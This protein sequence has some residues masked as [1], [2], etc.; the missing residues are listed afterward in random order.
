MV[1]T[2]RPGDLITVESAGLRV[3][4]TGE[5]VVFKR[6]GRLVVHRVANIL[7]TPVSLTDGKFRGR[8]NPTHLV[9]RGDRAG[10][11]DS[12]TSISELVGRVTQ[13]ERG[14][15]HVRLRSNLTPSEKVISRMLLFSDRATFLYLRI[16]AL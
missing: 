4:T 5:I 2:L 14:S 1:P 7:A 12:A 15:K 8:L 10:R 6:E 13:I 11:D 9:T 16:A 3:I